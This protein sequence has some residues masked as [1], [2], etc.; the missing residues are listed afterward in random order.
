MG[1]VEDDTKV[2][3]WVIRNSSAIPRNRKVLQGKRRVKKRD[4]HD[5]VFRL[6]EF[7]IEM[8]ST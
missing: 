6:A 1:M 2:S 5:H 7:D 8:H 3:A 4:S